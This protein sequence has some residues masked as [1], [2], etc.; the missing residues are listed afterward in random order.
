MTPRS[1]PG[2]RATDA[3][4]AER[5]DPDALDQ[6]ATAAGGRGREGLRDEDYGVAG[7]HGA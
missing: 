6:S 2:S 5:N 7:F 1:A 3:V 4:D